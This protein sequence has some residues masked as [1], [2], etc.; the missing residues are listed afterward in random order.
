MNSYISRQRDAEL[1]L[2]PGKKSATVG[3]IMWLGGIA[4]K[5]YQ[6]PAYDPGKVGQHEFERG[7]GRSQDRYL[8]KHKRIEKIQT[9]SYN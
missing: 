8:R 9:K 3:S 7:Q 2:S 1:V 4:D 5:T 6:D